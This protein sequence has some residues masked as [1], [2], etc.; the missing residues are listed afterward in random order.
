MDALIL[1]G[2]LGTRL[3]AVVK[4]RA[5]SV[6]EI[7]GRPFLAHVLDRLARSAEV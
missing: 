3:R 7:D 1:A 5:K 2:G 6:A 4:D